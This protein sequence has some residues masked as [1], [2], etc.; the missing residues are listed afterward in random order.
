MGLPGLQ[1][2]K[3]GVGHQGPRADVLMTFRI[4][5]YF[6]VG[7]EGLFVHPRVGS[8]IFGLCPL[9]AS[10]TPSFVATETVSGCHQISPG[11]GLGGRHSWLRITLRRCPGHIIPMRLAPA[12]QQACPPSCARSPSLSR[13]LSSWSSSPDLL[14][15]QG[16]EQQLKSPSAWSR[17]RSVQRCPGF[18][19]RQMEVFVL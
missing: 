7:G 2:A 9:V 4:G 1:G 14:Q 16:W 18:A 12:N 19:M 3:D 11:R 10:S 15:V 6:V 5:K 8:S 17:G 13:R